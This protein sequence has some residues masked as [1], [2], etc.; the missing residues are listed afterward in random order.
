[1]DRLHAKDKELDDMLNE[2]IGVN[3]EVRKQL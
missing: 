3:A 1:M 2:V